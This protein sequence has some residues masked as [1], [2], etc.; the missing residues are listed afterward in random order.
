M[1]KTQEKQCKNLRKMNGDI[2]SNMT[3]ILSLFHIDLVHEITFVVSSVMPSCL[4]AM[5][6]LYMHVGGNTFNG[7]IFLHHDISL[8]EN[9]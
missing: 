5:Y 1:Q 2:I 9:I 4:P 3:W 8:S 7:S 6:V